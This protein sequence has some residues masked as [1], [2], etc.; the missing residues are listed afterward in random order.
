ML[1][2]G[3]TM[4]A[5][6]QLL[7]VPVPVIARWREEPVPPRP[8]PA[9]RPARAP[10]P[11]PAA[12]PAKGSRFRTT[13]VVRRGFPH[14]WMRH[15]AVGYVLAALAVGVLAWTLHHPESL[16]DIVEVDV[17]SVIACAWWWLQRNQPLFTLT[18]DSIVVPGFLGRSSMPYADLA[19]WWL[20]MHV[21][22]E[23]KDEE[24]E[25]RLLSLHSRRAGVR[26]IGVF[27]HDHV[28]IDPAVTERLEQVKQA[29]RGDGPLT[30]MRAARQ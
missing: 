23:G 4:A 16:S 18:A 9:T 17:T 25:G 5:V 7:A 12:M 28:V 20:V 10:S 29:N 1:D 19:D 13:L 2:A 30:P 26:P 21:L 24:V 14:G 6:S 15:V 8:A 3:N 22:N 27:V 11:R